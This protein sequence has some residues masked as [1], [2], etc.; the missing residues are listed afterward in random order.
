M[1][2]STLMA[3][4]D[5]RSDHP[6]MPAEDRSHVTREDLF[7]SFTEVS[8][9]E[10]TALL[11]VAA[12]MVTTDDLLRARIRRE[13]TARPP[14]GPAWLAELSGID[15]YRAVEMVHPL[16]DGDNII[17]G[18][19]LPGGLEFT[20]SVYIDHNVGTLVKDAMVIPD[21]IDT[22][23]GHYQRL[24]DD[25]DTRWNELSLA[26]AKARVV[27]AIRVAAMTVP[28]FES[29]DW[30]SSRALVEWV[31]DRLPDGGTEYVHPEWDPAHI[32]EIARRFFASPAG[33]RMNDDEHRDLLDSL[34]WYGTDYGNGDPLRWSPVKVEILLV[35]WLP[36]TVIAPPE[37]LAKAPDLLRAFVRFAHVESGIRADLTLQTLDAI[38]EWQPHFVNA[39]G[40]GHGAGSMLASRGSWDEDDGD[41]DMGAIVL[42]TLA[43]AAGGAAALARLDDVELPDEPFDWDGIADDIV[44]RVQDVLT[45]VDQCCDHLL[46]VEYRTASRRLLSRAAVGEP[47]IFRRKAKAETA[48]AAVVWIVGKA[49]QAFD[50]RGFRLRAGDLTEYLGVKGTPSQRA[51]IFLRAA[52]FDVHTYDLRLDATFLV[53]TKRA[54]MVELRDYYS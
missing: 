32:A 41:D 10:T 35:D 36:R 48:A 38:D 7:A 25:P 17:L 50:G 45:L 30:P 43:R 49:N 3:V 14:S 53:S 29:E 4:T 46:D 26:D 16:G 13:L 44:P 21:S 11:T 20:C 24:N 47:A 15:S 12:Q 54:R 5:T 23:V 8:L 22:V 33:T 9:P 28:P 27:G 37:Y 51:Q 40:S 42:D 19:R 1:L 52:G 31:I 18:S 34:L 2:V 39:I 6:L